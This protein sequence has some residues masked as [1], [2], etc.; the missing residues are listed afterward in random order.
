MY[1][2]RSHSGSSPELWE[3]TWNEG[4]L[5]EAMRFCHL[6]P[7]RPLFERYAKPGS[8]MLEGGCGLGQY[9]AHYSARGVRVVGLDFA[10]FTLSRLL[11]H[12]S[13]LMVCAG[14]VA[15]LPFP[16]DTFDLYYSGGVVEHFEEGAEKALL[17]ARRVLRPDGVL[18]ISV[19]YFN[20]LRRALSR[21]SK[22]GQRRVS[23]SAK[24]NPDRCEEKQFW[25]YAYT[26][27]EFKSLLKAA[28]LTV[29]ST[30]GYAILFGLYELPLVAQTVG[31]CSKRR[32]ANGARE[33][34]ASAIEG[35]GTKVDG[36]EPGHSLLKRLIVSEDDTVPVAGAF[37]HALRETCANMMMYVCTRDDSHPK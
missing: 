3:E 28:G 11:A 2:A 20:P 10:R 34:G 12:D 32:P 22:N 14:N 31:A 33:N 18:L 29:V 17:E 30:R 9:V 21:F 13:S 7:L 25:Q 15:T 26:K 16:D 27:R 8:L 5:Q 23:L 19:P 4:S 36:G 6:D 37:L 35:A 1:H 24:D